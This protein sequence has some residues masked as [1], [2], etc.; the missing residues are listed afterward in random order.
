MNSGLTVENMLMTLPDVL[1]NDKKIYAIATAIAKA[2]E[3]RPDEIESLIIY[4]HIDT[5][6]ETLLDIL[7]NDFKVDWYDVEYTIDE[8]RKVL[9]NSSKVHKTLGTK[10][11]VETAM[12]AIYPNTKVVEWFDY[13]GDPY[14]F[15]LLIDTIYESVDPA[16]HQRVLDRI[17]YYKN[18][19]SHFDGIEY[20]AEANATASTYAGIGI[21]SMYGKMEVGVKVYGLE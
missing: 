4:T 18:Q 20:I 9:K 14:H 15:K 17:E 8:K 19:R 21:Y 2:L 13:D 16:K 3:K 12:S 1:K 10:G 5:M 11:A 7:A 6:P